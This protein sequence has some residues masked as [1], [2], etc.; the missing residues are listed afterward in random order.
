MSRRALSKLFCLCLWLAAT[1][2]LAQERSRLSFGLRPVGGCAGLVLCG[3]A[4]LRLG[5]T[6]SECGS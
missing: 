6:A 1:P 5:L 2:A 3:V 4:N